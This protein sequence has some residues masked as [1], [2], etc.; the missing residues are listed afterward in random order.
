MAASVVTVAGICNSVGDGVLFDIPPRWR[1]QY[2]PCIAGQSSVP[3]PSPHASSQCT[4]QPP[5]PL[6]IIRCST[7]RSSWRWV[8]RPIAAI[9]A[10]MASFNSTTPFNFWP[11]SIV[12]KRSPVS[13]AAEHLFSNEDSLSSLI[14]TL[15]W[16]NTMKCLTDT[17]FAIMWTRFFYTAVRAHI[18]ASTTQVVRGSWTS[19][20]GCWQNGSLYFTAK[21]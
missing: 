1:V 21:P 10:T 12:S 7:T 20:A 15:K 13:A 18:P 14:D 3:F 8:A 9:V 2:A 19:Y 5:P 16:I 4:R 11:M 6:L 17:A